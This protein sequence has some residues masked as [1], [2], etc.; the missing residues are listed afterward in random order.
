L[1]TDA[2]GLEEIAGVHGDVTSYNLETTN[3]I[4]KLSPIADRDIMYNK[5]PKLPAIQKLTVNP[6]AISSS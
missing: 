6:A 3:T 4:A 1:V 5:L 2:D